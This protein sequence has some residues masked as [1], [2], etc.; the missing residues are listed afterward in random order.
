[1]KLKIKDSIFSHQEFSTPYNNSLLLEWD[2]TSTISD[3]D[4]VVYT[5]CNLTEY[6]EK[7]PNNIAWLI[8]PREYHSP[9]YEWLEKHYSNFSKIWTHDADILKLPN[10][11]VVP[12][13]GCWISPNDQY[14]YPKNKICN[15]IASGK[16]QL[17]GH[18]LR[19]YIANN[20]N[21]FDKFGYYYNPVDH[22]VDALKDYMFSIVIENTKSPWYFTE[23]IIDCF[24][25]GTIPIYWGC[26]NISHFFN[27][28]GLL[29]FNTFEELES[30]L[31]SLTLELY[32]SK[33]SYVKQN[34]EIANKY[35]TVEDW[36][37]YNKYI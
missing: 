16:M 20:F 12:W 31:N 8:E 33:L 24:K 21:G 27:P 9:Y 35:L 1:M 4:I 17:K 22:K 26:E 15:L 32:N 7:N 5:D 25:T 2:R 30:I 14:I 18:R 36:L 28:E 13:G 29:I 6:R 34:F 11:K 3:D 37:I 19:H 23:K 10:S